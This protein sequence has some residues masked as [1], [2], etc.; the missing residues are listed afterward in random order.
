MS[1]DPPTINDLMTDELMTNEGRVPRL[2]GSRP[3]VDHPLRVSRDVERELRLDAM[4][5]N[6]E[7]LR[8]HDLDEHPTEAAKRLGDIAGDVRAL[9]GGLENGDPNG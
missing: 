5:D 4:E 8:E 1:D 2:T 3:I 6:I 7:W 9:I